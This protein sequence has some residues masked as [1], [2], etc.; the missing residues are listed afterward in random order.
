MAASQLQ[1]SRIISL[2]H[3][4]KFNDPSFP[5]AHVSPLHRCWG[6][7]QGTSPAASNV[8]SDNRH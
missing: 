3:N 1:L 5:S 4:E 8:T 7:A 2:T 6:W